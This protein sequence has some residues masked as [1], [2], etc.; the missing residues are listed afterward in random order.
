M[1]DTKLSI[2]PIIL[3]TDLT[4]RMSPEEAFQ[5]ITIRPI[6]KL[7]HNLLIEIMKTHINSNMDFT[8]LPAKDRISLIENIFSN[9]ITFKNKIN[10]L[11]IGLFTVDEFSQ[12]LKFEKDLNKRITSIIKQRILSCIHLFI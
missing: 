4:S 6:I 1:K 10:F 2:R 7:Q 5:N 8:S 12:Y 11:I 9:N 3:S